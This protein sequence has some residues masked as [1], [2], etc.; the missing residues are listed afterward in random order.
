MDKQI[1]RPFVGL[2]PCRTIDFHQGYFE[3]MAGLVLGSWFARLDLKQMVSSI[4]RAL[5]CPVAVATLLPA[6]QVHQVGACRT[7]TQDHIDRV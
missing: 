7:C 2:Y 1:Q 3:P 6:C 5:N 4:M